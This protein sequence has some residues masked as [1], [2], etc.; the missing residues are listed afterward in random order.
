MRK[1]LSSYLLLF[2]LSCIASIP[3]LAQT[4][5]SLD[6]PAVLSHT[7]EHSVLLDVVKTG[8]RIVAVGER[9]I[10]VLSDDSGR[11]WR[12]AVV[13]TS[14]SLTKVKFVTSQTGWIVGHSGVVLHTRDGGETWTRQLDG[15]TAAQLVLEATQ[16]DAD[17]AGSA[18]AA[19]ARALADAQRLVSDGPD[20]PFLDLYF[21]DEKTGF[22]VG[23]YGLIFRTE[24]GGATWKSWMSHVDNP[25][26]MHIYSIAARGNNLYLAGEQGL[27]LHSSDGGNKFTAVV[28]PYKG[29]YF[30]IA[31]L[32]GGEV[33]LGGMRGNAYRS[34]DQGRSFTKVALPVPVSLSASAVLADGTAVFSNQAGMLLITTDQ[35]KSMRP[36]PTPGLPPIAGLADAGNGM[37]MT[38]GYGGVIPVSIGATASTARNGGAQ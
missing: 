16:A 7:A 33:V 34:A 24:D 23:A 21:Q 32:P 12:Q 22:V 27:F 20:K 10:V 8:N 28:T 9:G 29:T 11:T 14:V 4:V 3:I 30:T 6:R 37:L 18:N 5:D 25:R 31:L 17:R 2:V 13:P 38:V 35:G 1:P 19:A 26:G 36:L 15:K